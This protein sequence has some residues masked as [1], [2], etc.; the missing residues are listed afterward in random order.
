MHGGLGKDITGHGYKHLDF[1]LYNK[2]MCKMSKTLISVL[3]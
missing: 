1:S 2:N 3:L